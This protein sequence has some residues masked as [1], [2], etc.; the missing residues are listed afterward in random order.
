MKLLM[1]A[2]TTLVALSAVSSVKLPS[3]PSLMNPSTQAKAGELQRP[4]AKL[5]SPGVTFKHAWVYQVKFTELQD[6]MNVLIHEVQ[7][8]VSDVLEKSTKLTLQQYQSHIDEVQSEYLP[9]LELFNELRP[10]SCRNLAENILN[11][12]T[13]FTGFAASNC[14]NLYDI[15]VRTEIAVA[16]D[17]FQQFDSLYSQ[18]QTIVVRAFIAQNQFVDPEAIEDTITEVYDV[19]V[20]RWN[21]SR[22]EIEAV[23]QTLAKAVDIQNFELGQ[24]HSVILGNAQWGFSRFRQMVDTCVEF[25]A[26]Q[27]SSPSKTRMSSHT[28]PHIALME[29]FKAGFAKLK[30]YEWQA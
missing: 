25:D 8:A 12:T 26:S 2:L 19:V 7:T 24:C 23:K 3:A 10:S 1:L 4:E 14:A 21:S 20:G 22:P 11:D 28:E 17:A 15:R 27:N 13:S 9:A 5:I 18:V 16:N 29:E 30:S 6:D